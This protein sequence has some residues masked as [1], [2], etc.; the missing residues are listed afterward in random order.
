MFDDI[1]E[2]GTRYSV[3]FTDSGLAGIAAKRLAVLT[4]IDSRID[5]LGILGLQP[6]DAKIVRNA[7]ARVTPDALRSLVLAV[8]LLDVDRICIVQHTDCA[9]LGHTNEELRERV[10]QASGV[11][12][13]EWD[14]LAASDPMAALRADFDV[15]E[16]SPFVPDGVEV[17]GFRFDV[18]SGRLSLLVSRVTGG[19]AAR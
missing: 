4:C 9:I 16:R 11:E 5:P 10:T 18:R 14:F 7:G 3:T 19:G 15:L 13:A 1:L 2:A 8:N 17:G 12:A 6:G